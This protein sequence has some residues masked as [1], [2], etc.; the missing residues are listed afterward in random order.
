MRDVSFDFVLDILVVVYALKV[1][2]SEVK[3]NI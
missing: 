2:L 3:V 1:Y